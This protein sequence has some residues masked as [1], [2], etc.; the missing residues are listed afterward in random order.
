MDDKEV[1][2]DSVSLEDAKPE[3]DSVEQTADVVEQ[4]S[5]VGRAAE[6]DVVVGGT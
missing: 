5:V 2:V 4:G 3:T 6:V 1:Q